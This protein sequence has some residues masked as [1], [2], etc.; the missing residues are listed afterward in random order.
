MD[1]ASAIF[2]L[3]IEKEVAPAYVHRVWR[4]KSVPQDA[5]ISVAL[6]HWQVVFV[7]AGN[8]RRQVFLRGPESLATESPIPQDCEFLGVEFNLG[9]HMSQ[10]P[11]AADRAFELQLDAQGFFM[12]AGH[13]REWPEFDTVDSFVGALARDGALMR[14]HLV[15]DLLKRRPTDLTE[16]TLQRRFLRA[17]GLTYGTVRQIHRVEHAVELLSQGV[18]ILDTVEQLGFSDQAHLTRAMR[19]FRG[20]TPA[21]I[22]KTE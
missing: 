15:E 11:L 12:L 3:E 4:T 16:R 14:D 18:P 10:A 7:R 5:F 8:G 19:R 17:T 20:R 6:P 9:V 22:Q 13:R 1:W 2:P 21:S